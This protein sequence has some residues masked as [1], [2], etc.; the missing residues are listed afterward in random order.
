[1]SQNGYDAFGR[2]TSVT[3]Y[4]NNEAMKT[5]YE[6]NALSLPVKLIDAKGNIRTW[7]YDAP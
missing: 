6:Y 1:M 2:L 4:T 5:Q 7:Q 3:T